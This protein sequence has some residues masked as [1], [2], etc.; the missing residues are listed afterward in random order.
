MHDDTGGLLYGLARHVEIISHDRAQSPHGMRNLA[1]LFFS[2]A[3]ST[4]RL[5]SVRAHVIASRLIPPAGRGTAPA[6]F[7]G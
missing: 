1:A 2:P 4:Y 3:A 5:A 7:V 6:V